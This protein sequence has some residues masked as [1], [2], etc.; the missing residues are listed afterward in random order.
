MMVLLGPVEKLA[1]RD[2]MKNDVNKAKEGKRPPWFASL[3]A[4]KFFSE[5]MPR[6]SPHAVIDPAANIAEDVEIGPFCVIGPEVTIG[7]GC[8]LLNSVTVLGT[9][10]IGKDNVFFPNA[11]IGA[12]PQDKK[13]KGSS[14]RLEIG[15]GNVFREAA[16]LHT[17]TEKGGG[18]TSVGD[19]GLYMVNCHIGHDSQIGD[20]VVI[21][22]N[23]MISGHVVVGDYV[24][25]MGGAGVHHFATIGKHA[26]VGAYSRIHHD[27]PPFCKVDGA[28]QVRAVNATG[29]RRAGFCEE[30]IGA[31]DEACRALFSRRKQPFAVTL[32]EYQNAQ[33]L[34]PHVK[35]LID[36]LVQRDTGK[37]GRFL[38]A[39]RK[40][41][42]PR[43]YRADEDSN[44]EHAAPASP[45][46][47]DNDTDVPA[48]SQQPDSVTS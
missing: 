2:T 43:V 47:D 17:G 24:A 13:F 1:V 41:R 25:M 14:T 42:E 12:A 44:G 11:V 8:R 5:S 16:T 46:D 7:S 21:S 18:I 38:E 40:D 33:G 45:G 28:D 19:N 36:F 30:D 48:P 26:Y 23:V 15:S 27:V 6:I 32:G 20:D 22:N 37:N 39:Q 31:I 10:T 35:F 3:F 34:N 29:L 9:T 4:F